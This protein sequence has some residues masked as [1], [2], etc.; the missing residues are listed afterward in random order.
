MAAHNLAKDMKR[1]AAEAAALLKTLGNPR[2]LMILCHI[3]KEQRC[4][5]DLA[6]LVGLS[7]SA[8]S[9]HLARLKAEGIVETE[10]AGQI[11]YYAVKD[12]RAKKILDTLYGLYCKT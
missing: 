7:Q 10:R 6:E 2:R 4:V 3:A 9:Q 12:H 8:L 1:N 5:G 11:I